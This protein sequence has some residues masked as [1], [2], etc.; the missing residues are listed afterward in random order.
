MPTV[1]NAANETAVESFIAGQIGFLDISYIVETTC[2]TSSLSGQEALF[3]IEEALA[4]DHEARQVAREQ[5]PRVA[6]AA[7]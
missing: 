5:L 2:V 3:S 1:L 4:V 6:F 7:P